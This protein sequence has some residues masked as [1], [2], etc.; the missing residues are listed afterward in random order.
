MYSQMHA[1]LKASGAK[2]SRSPSR[3]EY[4]PYPHSFCSASADSL[5]V[6]DSVPRIQRQMQNQTILRTLLAA[7]QNSLPGQCFITTISSETD[8]TMPTGSCYFVASL[9]TSEGY[10]KNVSDPSMILRNTASAV[11]AL[12]TGLEILRKEEN[13]LIG[14]V[15]AVRIN[16]GLFGVPWKSMKALLEE[17]EIDMTVLTPPE[18]ASANPAEE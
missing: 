14:E 2:V 4:F 6:P 10:G 3:R 13:R 17:K 5:V 16:S 18:S 7:H 15:Y 8:P 9:I 1:T 11:G 12:K